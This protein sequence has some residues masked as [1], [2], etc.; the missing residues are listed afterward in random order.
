[1]LVSVWSHAPTYSYD[2]RTPDALRTIN[3]TG[4]TKFP[5]RTFNEVQ[6]DFRVLEWK[7][8]IVEHSRHSATCANHSDSSPRLRRFVK[9]AKLLLPDTVIS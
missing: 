9:N 2:L 6:A 8:Q 1:M 4:M 7:N 3:I 5:T